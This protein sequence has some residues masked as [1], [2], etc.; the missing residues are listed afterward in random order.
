MS[1]TR[2]AAGAALGAC[3]LAY[4]FCAEPLQAACDFSPSPG[5]DDYRCDSGVAAALVDPQGNNSLV[6]PAGGSGTITG[7]VSFGAGADRIEV[8][9]GRIGGA[10]SQ[11]DGIDSFRMSGGQIQSLSQGDGFDDFVM[12]GGTI[13]GAFEGGDAVSIS[14][15]SI[16]RVDIGLGANRFEMSGGRILANLVAGFDNDTLSI[17]GGSVGGNVSLSSGNDR[18]SLSG[19]DIGG[20]VLMGAG[21]DALLWLGGGTFHGGL[22]MAAGDDSVSVTAVPAEAFAIPP[23]L[24][25]GPGR[26]SLLLEALSATG[27]ARYLNWESIELR[28]GARLDLDDS[29]VLGDSLSGQGQLRVDGGSFLTSASGRIRA[30]TSGQPAML[31]NAGTIDL[32]RSGE[33]TDDSLTVLGDY[34]GETGRLL[35][36]AVLAGDGA[37]ADR[38]IVGQ[39][40]L[41]GSTAIVL[42][43]LGGSG[44]LTRGDGILLVEANQGASSSDQ[45]FSLSQGLSVGAYQYYLFKGGLTAG[46]ENSWYLRSSVA[47]PPPAPPEPPPPP[48]PPPPPE[49]P[50]PPPVPPEEPA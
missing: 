48:L 26:D 50:A 3:T 40:R 35:L 18:L 45:A 49:E 21:N 25:G 31:V 23:S 12:S 5:N 34:R 29:L 24:D 17:S 15:G 44:G 20:Q 6:L 2:G 27:G 8:A 39:G 11:G 9:S 13:V 41:D 33:R 46:T 47:A 22:Q 14:G 4:L 1:A 38:L 16:G 30:F 28:N 43:N 42:S 7:A 19:G 37:P 32:T 36:Q 10:V